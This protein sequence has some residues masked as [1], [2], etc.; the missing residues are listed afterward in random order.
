M[1]RTLHISTIS[2][3]LSSPNI[4]V[5]HF[6][7]TWIP[8]TKDLVVAAIA[9]VVVTTVAAAITTI[10]ATK[11]PLFCMNQSHL[12]QPPPSCP[13]LALSQI[14]LGQKRENKTQ[15]P[16]FPLFKY[17]EGLREKTRKVLLKQIAYN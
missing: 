8:K 12:S 7:L 1:H 3:L 15:I 6:D 13:I 11:S 5:A 2:S 16:K 9:I 17:K 14:V 4:S 10:Q